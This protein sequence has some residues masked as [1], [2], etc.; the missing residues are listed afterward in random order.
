VLNHEYST[1]TFNAINALIW[2]SNPS[3]KRRQARRARQAEERNHRL[4]AVSYAIN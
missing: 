4:L 2:T 3:L 1:A